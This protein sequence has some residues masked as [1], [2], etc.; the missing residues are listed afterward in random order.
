MFDASK[1]DKKSRIV[2]KY[3]CITP[4]QI[5]QSASSAVLTQILSLS[6]SFSFEADF[7]KATNSLKNSQ[8][9]EVDLF[10]VFERGIYTKNALMQKRLT[11]M[12][13]SEFNTM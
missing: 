7:R 2:E 13:T 3:Q 10:R 4:D 5:K 6:G 1:L 11:E 9:I 8:C 12:L